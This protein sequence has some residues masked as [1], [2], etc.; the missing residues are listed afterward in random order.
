MIRNNPPATAAGLAAALTSL[1]TALAAWGVD[2]LPAS[3]P[4]Q[5]VAAVYGL[6]VVF[7]GLI[8]ALVGKTAQRWTWP[9]RKVNELLD[10]E[11][12]LARVE[13]ERE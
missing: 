11:T 7:A 9:D 6:V 5:V 2:L 10:A 4:D 13:A 1:L 8:G 3:I 12:F